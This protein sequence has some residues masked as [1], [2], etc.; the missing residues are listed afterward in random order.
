MKSEDQNI[1]IAKFCGV[2]NKYVLIKRGLYYRPD[3]KGYTNNIDE[4][5]KYTKAEAEKDAQSN[6]GEVIV[7]KLPVTDYTSDLNAMHIAEKA[8]P[9]RDRSVYWNE[10]MMSVGPDGEVDLVDDY[11]EQ[12]TSPS[13]S[14]FSIVHATAKQRSEAFLKTL[15]LWII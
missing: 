5:G 3:Y 14:G 15:N 12:S 13:T 10:L 9:I 11:G 8:I 2:E 4:A 6:H 1:A 7:R